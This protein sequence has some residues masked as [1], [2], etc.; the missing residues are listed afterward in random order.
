MR[1]L[2]LLG[3]AFCLATVTAVRGQD[4]KPLSDREI[5]HR[6]TGTWVSAWGHGLTTTNIIAADGSYVSRIGG[7]TNGLTF[8]YHG[9]FL[10]TNGIVAGNMIYSNKTANLRLH[11]I[12]LDSHELV[13]SN[14]GGAK[15]ST[16]HK[17][18]D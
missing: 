4:T 10:A 16:F 18:G 14:E 1:K 3:L 2:T 6:L 12:R 7:L 9:T 15:A 5:Q 11:I 13:W 8:Q 17:V